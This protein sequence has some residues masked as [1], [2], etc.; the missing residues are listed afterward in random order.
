MEKRAEAETIPLEIWME[1]Q[2]AAGIWDAYL[3]NN[4]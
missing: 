4:I 3:C 1:M 2:V